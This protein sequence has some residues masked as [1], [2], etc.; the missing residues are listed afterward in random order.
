M[1]A[2]TAGSENSVNSVY[3]SVTAT[4]RSVVR[5]P[6]SGGT[7]SLHGLG[8]DCRILT[9][10]SDFSYLALCPQDVAIIRGAVHRGLPSSIPAVSERGARR[11]SASAG[12]RTSEDRSDRSAHLVSVRMWQR[13]RLQAR[14]R[15]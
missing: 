2:V 10:G 1:Y 8:I 15:M 7:R 6:R 11:R 9:D 5:S 12:A 13:R 4:S 3:T 14:S